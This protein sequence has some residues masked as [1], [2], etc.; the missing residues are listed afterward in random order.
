MW[1]SLLD[2]PRLPDMTINLPVRLQK[3]I[4]DE[5]P[6][7]PGDLWGRTRKYRSQIADL[8]E[9]LP[10]TRESPPRRPVWCDCVHHQ[11]EVTG[12][13]NGGKVMA[14]H[15]TWHRWVDGDPA[16]FFQKR[17]GFERGAAVDGFA[18]EAATNV[19]HLDPQRGASAGHTSQAPPAY[20][21]SRQPGG[22]GASDDETPPHRDHRGV[23]AAWRMWSSASDI[24][25]FR[26]SSR[27]S[28]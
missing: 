18:E 17:E 16:H 24:V 19:S 27:R 22:V 3:R 12:R 21:T 8:P 4:L 25:P 20:E 9:N 10:D 28:L 5:T 26:P 6:A 13:S 7:I 14:S 15:P 11:V 1:R 2:D 23:G